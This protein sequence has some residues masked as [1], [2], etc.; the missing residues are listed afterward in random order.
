MADPDERVRRF[1]PIVDPPP[2]VTLYVDEV[3]RACAL[4]LI[5]RLALFR[6]CAVLFVYHD[7]DRCTAGSR[8]YCARMCCSS[9]R[10]P[11]IKTLADSM[12]RWRAC[13]WR[14]HTTICCPASKLA[15][16]VAVA[17]LAFIR[18]SL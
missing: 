16:L 13:T 12:R 10:S 17:L 9:K 5:R 7:T 1:A 6:V 2:T 11:R 4:Q 3:G 8:S 14:L 15:A 18:A